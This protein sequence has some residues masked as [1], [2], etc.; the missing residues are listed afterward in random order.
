MTNVDCPICGAQLDPTVAKK[1]G[2]DPASAEMLHEKAHAGRIVPLVQLGSIAE[3]YLKPEMLSLESE[4]WKYVNKMIEKQKQL[5]KE[6]AEAS[7]DEKTALID[8]YEKEMSRVQEELKELEEDHKEVLEGIRDG[9]TAI[10]KKIVGVGMGK[11]GE[12]ITIKDLQASFRTD[13]FTDKRS[14]EKGSDIVAEVR[15]GASVA[16]QVVISVKFQERWSGSFIDQLK[17]NMSEEGTKWGILVT[18]VFPANALNDRAYFTRDGHFIVKPEYASVAYYGLR[19]AVRAA[20]ESAKQARTVEERLRQEE[21]I[22]EA[23][24]N[25]VSGEKFREVSEALDR[26]RRAAEEA[27]DLVRKWQ[28]YAKGQGDK[29]NEKNREII[30]ELTRSTDLLADLKEKLGPQ[31][32]LGSPGVLPAKRDRRRRQAR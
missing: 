25:W 10:G 4:F 32:A 29:V 30:E 11:V 27:Q 5:V 7:E 3:N 14:D 12:S 8:K 28:V 21:R 26:A 15:D 1:V 6:I 31:V 18:K 16:G 13:E 17:R 24:R 22:V 19:E 20:W 9:I 2:L 23:L